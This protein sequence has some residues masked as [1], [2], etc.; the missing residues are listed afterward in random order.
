[1]ENKEIRNEELVEEITE[2]TVAF[3]QPIEEV[4]EMQVEESKENWFKQNK[5]TLIKVGAG[6]AVVAGGLVL[7]SKLKKMD[8]AHYDIVEEAIEKGEELAG[9]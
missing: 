9:E 7:I 4:A 2:E 5:K 8:L 3:E 6:A 1:M